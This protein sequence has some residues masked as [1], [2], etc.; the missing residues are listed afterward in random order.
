MDF[1]EWII[2]KM[3]IWQDTVLVIL[4][5]L[6]LATLAGAIYVTRAAYLK[7]SYPLNK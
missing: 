2:L 1:L 3:H 5:P 7:N 6:F 4:V